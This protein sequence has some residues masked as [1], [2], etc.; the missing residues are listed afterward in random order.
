MKQR[1][2]PESDS[3]SMARRESAAGGA[4]RLIELSGLS[5]K[6]LALPLNAIPGV[7]YTFS[8]TLTSQVRMSGCGCVGGS[9]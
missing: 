1:G 3:A 2:T 7:T 4:A 6:G 9:S 5:G 8:F